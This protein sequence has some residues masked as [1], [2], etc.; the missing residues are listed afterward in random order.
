MSAKKYIDERVLLEA[1]RLL[2]HTDRAAK[3]VAAELGFADPSDFTKFF[4]LRTGT[5]PGEF[6]AR[7]LRAD[8][9]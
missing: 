8:G 5:T 6:R 4:R 7:A 3:D 9:T 1:E 2:P